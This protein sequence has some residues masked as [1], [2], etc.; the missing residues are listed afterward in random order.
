MKERHVLRLVQLILLLALARYFWLA[1]YVHPY[2][3][4]FSYA[5][6]G[7]R[8]ALGTRLVHEY[9]SWN[10]RY[11]SNILL[12]RGPLT[13]GLDQGL[14]LYRI[15][16]IGLVLFTWLAA[17][18]AVRALLPL[19]TRALCATVALLFVLLFLHVMPDVSE[20]FYWY[21]GAMTYQLPNALSLLLVANWVRALRTPD[22][23]PSIGWY[24]VQVALIVMIA[25]CNEVH[26]AFLVL[27]AL[28]SLLFVRKHHPALLRPASRLLV[29]SLLCA[30][31]VVM[32]PGNSTRGAHFPLRH[33]V[34]RTLGYSV[35]QTARFA[36]NAL[37][38]LPV[39]LLSFT[40]IRIRREAIR[41]GIMGQFHAPIDKWVA[42]AL[43]FAFLFVAMV[44]TYWP[45][46]LLGQHRTVNM[47]LF[48]F[49]PGWFFALAVWDQTFFAPRG[50]MS[51][52][53]FVSSWYWAVFFVCM[54][55]I[56][57]G[58]DLE[59]SGELCDGTMV[60]YDEAMDERYR[61]IA[62]A[63]SD[64]STADIVL[65]AVQWPSCLDILPLD[66]SPDHW[67][68][69]SMADYFGNAQLNIIAPPPPAPSE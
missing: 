12:L 16:A 21:T 42:L 38:S 46:G 65:P 2:A 31:V 22:R 59:L 62:Q 68:N 25:G 4:D 29:V 11:F 44:V 55:F 32:A 61:V 28:A 41:R 17:H 50:R 13:L 30:V 52:G 9:T 56:L 5:V 15:A 20:G 66:P 14:W 51:E 27:A 67:M 63:A 69:R 37:V 33:D 23:P 43:P 60:H 8:S 34:L 24:I 48:Y 53:G 35:A 58:R 40:F 7:M 47:A 54:C 45:T 36:G 49:I 10:G 6:A 1:C 26:M 39:L 57:H 19:A 64:G 3:D 18:R